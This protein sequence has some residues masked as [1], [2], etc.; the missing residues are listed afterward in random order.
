MP[1]AD[2]I[3]TLVAIKNMSGI[4]IREIIKM[5]NFPNPLLFAAITGPSFAQLNIEIFLKGLVKND[6]VRSDQSIGFFSINKEATLFFTQ[7]GNQ[8][9][10]EMEQLVFRLLW[11]IKKREGCTLG[12]LKE[13]WQ[14]NRGVF[15]EFNN[16][17]FKIANVY[18]FYGGYISP[19]IWMVDEGMVEI[20][21]A[22]GRRS[23]D[24]D[25]N[26]VKITSQGEEAL[27]R[28]EMHK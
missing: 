22:S 28:Q 21:Y 10:D 2:C 3:K 4:K 15:D 17:V 18:I 12:Q 14:N 6:Y 16:R 5:L 8:L 24:D 7:K 27:L 25:L 26:R 1:S 19:L 11:F 13:F 20:E 23:L 9:I